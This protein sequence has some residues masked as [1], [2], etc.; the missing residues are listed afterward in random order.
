MNVT[1]VKMIQKPV[2]MRIPFF[3]DGV[4]CGFPSP[5]DNYIEDS[6]DLNE[7]LI[8]SPASTYIL[9]AKGDSMYDAIQNEDLLIVDKSLKPKNRDIIIAAFYG[10]FLVKQYILE[11]DSIWLFPFNEAYHPIEIDEDDEFYCFGVVTHAI[12]SFR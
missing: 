4:A 2:K 7:Y 3:L 11:G 5:A 10:E 1:F 8:Q 6:L 12:H 9:R